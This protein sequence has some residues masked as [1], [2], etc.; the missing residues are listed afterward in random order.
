VP[1]KGIKTLPQRPKKG[2]PKG[3]KKKKGKNPGRE[4]QIPVPVQ[5]SENPGKKGKRGKRATRAEFK[6]EAEWL[7][8]SV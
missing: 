7:L 1:P 5:T 2:F 3:G 8:T 6:K 4:T